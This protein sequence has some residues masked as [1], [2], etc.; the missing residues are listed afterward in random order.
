MTWKADAKPKKAPAQK[1]F[2]KLTVQ[3]AADV[4]LKDGSIGLSREAFIDWREKLER[5]SKAEKAGLSEE[6]LILA[7]RF[8]REA[9]AAATEIVAQL[10]VFAADLNGTV[11]R[12][13]D[14]GPPPTE[15]APAAPPR[16]SA[17]KARAATKSAP[18]SAPKAQA[19]PAPA[20]PA[21]KAPAK[22]AA[23]RK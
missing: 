17:P 1:T 12:D 13:E 23:K 14:F 22:S 16:P 3:I 6:L 9:E 8:F 2:G 21:A 18:K 19:K 20:K 15:A 11:L 7:G 10:L 5:L 4:K